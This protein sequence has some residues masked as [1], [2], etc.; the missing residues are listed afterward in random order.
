MLSGFRAC[1]L[2]L[3]AVSLVLVAAGCGSQTPEEKLEDAFHLIGQGQTARGVLRLQ[4]LV[5][6][7]PDDPAAI[8]AHIALARYYS[9][10]GNAPR[11]LGHLTTVYENTRVTDGR[12]QEAFMGLVAINQFTGETDTA[13]ELLRNHIEKFPETDTDSRSYFR[14]ELGEFLLETAGEGDEKNQERYDEGYEI[15]STMMLEGEMPAS[16]GRAREI[17][18]RHHRQRGQFDESNAVYERYIAAF[19]DD[20]I[21]TELEIA[22]ALNVYYSGETELGREMFE[23]AAEALKLEIEEEIEQGVRARRLRELAT[24]HQSIGDYERA[25]ELMEQ[26]MAENIQS[27]IAIRTQFDIAGMYIEAGLRRLDDEKFERGAAVLEQI[28]REN[29]GTNIESTAAARLEQARQILENIRAHVAAMEAEELEGIDLPEGALEAL[30]ED[31]DAIEV[32]VEAPA[33]PDDQ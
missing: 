2:G 13:I 1:L 26:I 22:M 23:V 9:S 21:R 4:D 30:A 12:N 17:L 10:D 24:Y 11:A 14:I 16:R 29:P 6:D 15:L 31:L 33:E 18:A 27:E 5:R 20:A 19:P 28:Q 32:E 7:H 3:A 25:R 8:D